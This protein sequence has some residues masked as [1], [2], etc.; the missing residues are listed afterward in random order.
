MALI[1]KKHSIK[2][3]EVL[4]PNGRPKGAISDLKRK[5]IELRKKA[6]EDIDIAYGELRSSMQEGE[7]WAH[8]I[9]FKELVPFN[10]EWMAQINTQGI[11]NKVTT[12]EDLNACIAAITEK[13]LSVDQMSTEEAHNLVKTLN[14]IKFTESFGKQ[15]ENVLDKLNDDQVKQLMSWINESDK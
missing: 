12:V 8:Q 7:S 2:K 9:Y 1:A 10:K 14:N 3:G 11:P 5:S 6:M 4:N 15:K 13:L